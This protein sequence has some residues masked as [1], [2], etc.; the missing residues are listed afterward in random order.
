M[1][2]KIELTENAKDDLIKVPIFIREKLF[3]WIDT[4]KKTGMSQARKIRGFHD[5]PLKGKRKGQRSVRLN[6]AYR[7][8]YI[9]TS[10]KEIYLISIIE[11]NKHE[12]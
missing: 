10:N 11:V 7:A 12:Y 6:K 9:E 8:I 1:D 4:V 2:L 5:E 3:I